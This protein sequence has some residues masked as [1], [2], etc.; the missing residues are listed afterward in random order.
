MSEL[1]RLPV[2]AIIGR[3]NVGKS[4][5][6][7]QLCNSRI[8]IED[9]KPGTTRDRVS[10]HLRIGPR[11]IE[12]VDAAG[13]GM[14]DEKTL[15]SSVEEQIGFAIE[16]AD[17]LMVVVDIKEGILSL[18]EA[19]ARELRGKGKPVVLAANKADAHHMDGLA[20]VFHK[21][22]LGEPISVSARQQRGI[23]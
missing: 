12:L 2:V 6:F 11:Q 1:G 3:P 16:Q 21:L 4:S 10:F 15:E 14:I 17:V 19:V 18:D 22:G 9:A 13:V 23:E 7:N 8:S 20:G 5:L